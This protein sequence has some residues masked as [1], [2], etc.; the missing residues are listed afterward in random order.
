M[1]LKLSIGNQQGILVSSRYG[2]EVKK[3]EKKTEDD[4]DDGDDDEKV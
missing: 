3:K 2:R 4:L 1:S